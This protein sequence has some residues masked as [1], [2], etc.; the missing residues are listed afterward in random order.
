MNL[1][2]TRG[3]MA[4]SLTVDGV[5]EIHLTDEQRAEAKKRIAEW[6]LREDV[7]LNKI[8]ALVIEHFYDEYECDDEPCE[9]CGDYVET[10]KLE[11]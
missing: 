9:C 11:I 8:L 7:S 4:N 10:Y 2:L 5:E 1:E 3:C 6:L